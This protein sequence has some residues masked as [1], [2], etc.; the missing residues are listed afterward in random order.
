VLAAVHGQLGNAAEAGAA[1]DEFLRRGPILATSDD[2]LN[3]PFGSVE[4]REYFLDGLRKAGLSRAEKRQHSRRE[5]CRF[6]VVEVALFDDAAALG[7]PA[8][9]V[10]RAMDPED[11]GGLR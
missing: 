9:R 1:L 6:G 3:R 8:D 7:V 2:W 5:L 10:D 11:L 4:Q